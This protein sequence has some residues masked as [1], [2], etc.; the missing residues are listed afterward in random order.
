MK[1]HLKPGGIFCLPTG[2]DTDRYVT[3]DT[4][5]LL[6]I[7]VK[8]LSDSFGSVA[9]WPGTRTL[10]LA[11]DRASLDLPYDTL[12]TRLSDLSYQPEYVSDNYLI[13]RLNE[14]KI[15]RLRDR[16]GGGTLTNSVV[17]PLLP[18]YQLWFRAKADRTDREL[19]K[20][21][22]RRP[23]W[24]FGL[25]PLILAFLA[26]TLR[27]RH[28][29]DRFGLFLYFTA[30]VVSLSL[31]LLSFYVYQSTVGSLYSEMAVLIGTFML[32]LALGTYVASK[33]AR[34]GLGRLS[35]ATLLAATILF[36][37]T[38]SS[39][40]CRLVLVYHLLFLLVVALATGSLFVA[41]TRRYYA[42]R[43]NPNRGAGYACELAGSALGALLTTT[44]LLPVIGLHWL[45]VSLM[46]LLAVGLVL[47]LLKSA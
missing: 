30:G 7:I 34:P 4:R 2:Y 23:L 15:E 27:R 47:S 37:L 31:E 22:L 6:S 12:M 26:W 8:T 5:E 16:V 13:D 25:P 3:D 39:V 35:L 29:R 33:T 46:I 45:L 40:D 19:M 21:V 11:S 18:S 9:M 10:L 14:F 1:R 24:L 20:W 28:R 17:E 43:E 42:D 44:V 36:G 41:A 32:G 38:W